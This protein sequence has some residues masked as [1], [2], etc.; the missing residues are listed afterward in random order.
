VS[1]RFYT[2]DRFRVD[3]VKRLL[4][5]DGAPVPLTP[6]AFDILIA[7]TSRVCQLPLMVMSG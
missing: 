6:K 5:R 3:T 1:V 4:L 2:F 7:L